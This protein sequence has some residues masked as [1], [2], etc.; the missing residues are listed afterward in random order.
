MA[1]PYK[2]KK[3]RRISVTHP[4]HPPRTG[5]FQC[6]IPGKPGAKDWRERKDRMVVQRD[7]GCVVWYIPVECSKVTLIRK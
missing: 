2:L 7:D 5:I 3:G 4:D 1:D 6:I